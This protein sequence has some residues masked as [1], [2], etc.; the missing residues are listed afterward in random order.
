M[1]SARL[2]DNIF[3]VSNYSKQRIEHYFPFTRNKVIV[4]PNAVNTDSFY[5]GD[6]EVSRSNIDTKY[7]IKNY[8]L[9]V[10]RIEPR[11]QHNI[12]LKS[13]LDLKLDKEGFSL[14]FVGKKSIENHLL[15][16]L[17]NK[18]IGLKSFFYFESIEQSDL[19]DFFN[20]AELFVYPSLAEGFG[21]PPLEAGILKTPVLCSNKTAMSDFKF[22]ESDLFNPENIIEFESKLKNKILNKNN[23]G[24]LDHIFYEIQNNFNWKES[25]KKISESIK[26]N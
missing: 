24:R 17:L 8:I 6:K 19:R 4:T 13:F 15:N 10:S 12:L 3:T 20:A 14:V 1:V 5:L 7:G 18:N 23:N 26:T 22:F 25:A 11:K 2:A 9:Y 16:D 21:I